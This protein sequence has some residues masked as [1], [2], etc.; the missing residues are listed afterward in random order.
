MNHRPF[1]VLFAAVAAVA[2]AA[3]AVLPAQAQDGST[4]PEPPTG[5]STVVSH[6][7]VTL[8][9]DDPGDGTVVGYVVLRRDKD[10]H[11]QG[12]F[13]TLAPDTGSAATVYVDASVEP[14]RRYVYR[15]KAINA[16]GTSDRSTWVRAYT[17]AAEPASGRP[18]K[19]AGLISAFTHDSVTLAWDDPGDSTVVGYV[20]LRRDKDIHPQ[21]TF[22]T[23]TADTGTNATTYTDHTAQPERRYVYRIKA[24]NAHG[25]SDISS[26]VR[27]HTPAAPDAATEPSAAPD[28]ATEPSDATGD[29]ATESAGVGAK[30]PSGEPSDASGAGPAWSAV[31]TV[32][33]DAS[34]VPAA[35]GYSAWGLGGTLTAD[36]FTVGATAYRV[37]VLA[38]QSGG[39]VLGLDEELGADFTLTV[40]GVSYAAQD[41]SR[42]EA[43]YADAYWWDAHQHIDWSA[44]DTLEVSLT[45]ASAS[46]APGPRPQL[47][48][49]PPTA[50]FR[51]VPQSH[52]GADA[53]AFRLHFSQ[54][55]STSGETLRDHALEVA[56]GSVVNAEKVN[57]SDRI[58]EIAV[59]PA[60][61]GEVTVALR[62][63]LACDSPGAVCTADGRQPHN[64]PAVTIAGPAADP[65]AD[66][67]GDDPAEGPA[68]DE[69]TA[70]WSATM[71]ADRVHWGYG[72][73][74]T[75]AKRAGSLY[76]AQFEVDGTTYTVTMIETSGWMYIGTDR[77]LPFGFV[78]ELDGTR[79]ASA[80]ASY[81]S[82]SYGHIYQWRRTDLG[83]STGDTVEIRMLGAVDE[84]TAGRP[85]EA[86]VIK[87]TAQVGRTL[88]VDVSAIV[89]PNGLDDASFAYQWTAAGRDI[90]GADAASL[91]LTRD[92]RGKPIGVR[93]SFT[94]GAGNRETLT[95]AA[96]APVVAAPIGACRRAGP[97]P[98]PRPVEVEAVPVVVQSTA[99]KYYVL[100][101]LHDLD[102]G[103]AVEIPV[104]VTLGEAGS[105]T[106]AEELPALPAERYRVEEYLVADPGSVDRDCIDDVTELAELGAMNPLNRAPEVRPVDGAVAI[107][108][109]E[110]F[111]ALSAHLFGLEYVKFHLD[112][113]GTDRPI[114]YF[115]NTETYRAHS[116]FEKVIEDWLEENRPSLDGDY[117]RGQ[118]VYHPNVVARD[119]SLGVYRFEFRYASHSF[120]TIAHAQ[121]ILAASMPVLEDNLMYYPNPGLALEAY[122]RERALYDESRVRVLLE[123]D[124]FPDVDFMS[125]NRAEGYG[126]L[127]VMSLEER[128][129]PRDVVIY[130]TLPNELSRVAGIITTVPQT[131]L[132]HVNLRAV[133]DGVPNAFIRGALDNAD[134]DDLIDSFVHYTVTGSGW[135][136]RAA[137]P[138]EVDAHYAAS[139][140]SQ[141]QTPQR[142]LSVTEITALGDV[143]F[144][145]WT[146]FGVKAANVAV[147]GTLGFG[148]GTVPDGFAV[149]FYFYDEFMKH[150][151][152]Y[153][154][155]EEMLAD[156]D[157]QS[158][159]DTQQN[160][161]KK[162]RKKIK[163]AD[164]PQWIIE[165]L[166]AMHA[167]YPESQSLRYRSSTN[168]EDLPGFSGA[169]L[170][171]SKTQ[172]PD[173]T[174]ED[175][176]DKSI[177]GVWA[178]LWNFRA[179]TEREFH[180]IDHAAAAMGVLVHPNFSDELANGVAVS[181]DPFG[182]A[183]GSYY[184]NTQLGE[185]LVTNP[186]AH[187]VPEEMLL[188]PD[189]THTVMARSNQVP[190]G[191]LLLS[192]AQLDQLRRHLEAIHNHFEE[193]YGI[194]PGEEFA[195]EIEFKI[196]SDNIL[197]IKQA[198][199]WV[200]AAG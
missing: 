109:R 32:G 156:P 165:A 170:Y 11:L 8:S 55:V 119:G 164:T 148:D 133:Q 163:K 35:S 3:A 124:V 171:D 89:D 105:T 150:N 76:P 123:E 16:A 185:D 52:N 167:T 175:G 41:G 95:S 60:S 181:F 140:P 59:V 37:L 111:E 77:E 152:L 91:T 51:L 47:P 44:G 21:G 26:W 107:P 195:I 68:A 83:W 71:T 88:T 66:E 101:V 149:P 146:A 65:P 125:L 200:F 186:E 56:G 155:V 183:D 147:L 2:V 54:A 31:L 22:R 177:K 34:M 145:D 24:I 70:V 99:E 53:F 108:D 179:F 72:Y 188:H 112:G 138:A 114:I 118:I 169:G 197:S 28:G 198:R 25:R 40:G 104:S 50:Y 15:I 85:V 6:D 7:S 173:E 168:N 117:M 110:T 12:T 136:L 130:E 67:P 189:G 23:I 172:D 30:E 127:R 196:T 144:G 14:G 128:P 166:E 69:L 94:D 43:M 143:G 33:E 141:P 176:I 158:D 113:M 39:L 29:A 193:L 20:I 62:S 142:D 159:F 46:A 100:Y 161:L 134:V 199:P 79:F 75:A 151:G 115:Q 154:D 132:S 61:G 84:T 81:Q 80:D 160:K 64:S 36:T 129:D 103:T 96:T 17:P 73:Y 87:G 182:R 162:L 139:R 4:A 98:E 63:D 1:R 58:W 184:V 194:G 48:P 106:L 5:L 18:A 153:D 191:Q 45:V 9:W 10:I 13:V 126:F 49:A 187:S 174:A 57:E 74:S 178:S 116:R 157:F 135:T 90:A 190:A 121:E 86:P 19:P 78:L 102:D 92:E 180:R 38:Q 192:D 97:G 27:A 93:V 42:P 122:L 120:A 137:T 82:Y 131:P